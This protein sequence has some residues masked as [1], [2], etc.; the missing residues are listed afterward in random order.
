MAFQI[1]KFQS[2]VASMINFVSGATDKITDF[3]IGSVVR[4]IIESIALELEELYYQL[5]QA[6]QEAIEEAIYRTFNF[7]RNPS[8]RATGLVRFFRLTGTEAEI[9]IPRLTQM[10]TDTEPPIVF[11]SQSDEIIPAINGIATG[12]GTTSLIDITK[13][14]VDEGIVLG[15]RVV[16]VTDSGE[17]QA[18]GVTSITTTTNLNDTLNFGTLTGGASFAGGGDTYKVLGKY[19]D[20][21]VQALEPGTDSNVAANT[22]IILRSTLSNVE[23]IINLAAFSDGKNEETDLERKARFALYIQS[24][25]RATR[26]ALEYAARTVEQVIAAKAIDDVR[27]YILRF[28]APSSYVDIT[29][30]MRNPGDP[31]VKLFRDSE[32]EDDALM[33]GAKELF[34]YVNMH[35]VQLGVIAVNST[36]YEYYSDTGWKT[37]SVSD[38]TN[39]GT[40]PLTQSGTMSFTPPNDWVATTINNYNRLWIR[41]RITTS[42]VIYSTSPTGDFASLPPGFGYVYLYCHDGSGE[43]SS[44]LIAAVESAVEPYRGCG[45]IVEVKAPTKIQPTIETEVIIA[46]NYDVQDIADKLKQALIDYLNAKVLGDDLYIAE[47]YQFIMDYNDK[48]IINSEITLPSKDIIVPS[49]G[50]LRA[51]PALITVVAVSE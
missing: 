19:T 25:A 33:I 36:I 10:S 27:P 22:I 5:L 15:S 8:E 34:N 44:N 4:T 28:E 35:L 37:L 39:N 3:N 31:D 23:S 42:G 47:L 13:N 16:N 20:V 9:N 21:P 51:N 2:I 17:T 49:S 48:A 18:S 41:L 14:W 24:L 45:I 11:E 43:L 30:Q 40:G 26:G 38:G 50:V 12:G 7:P 46:Q 29:N 32:Q 6:V 1:K